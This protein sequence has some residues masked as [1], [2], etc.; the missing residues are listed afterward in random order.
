VVPQIVGSTQ[1]TCPDVQ[2]TWDS[3]AV[4]IGIDGFQNGYVE[5]TGTSSDCFYGQPS[6]Y[7]WYEMYPAGSVP[8]TNTVNPGDHMTAEVSYVSAT[9]LFT[10][11]ITDLTGHWTFTSAPTM[12]CVSPGVCA[13]ADSAEWIDESPYYEGFLGLTPVPQ[14]TMSG[15]SATINGVTHSISGWGSNVNWLAM[16]DYN[17]G[18]V[19]LGYGGE[20]LL[21]TK[22]VPLS[23]GMDGFFS[24]GN[25][26]SVTWISSGP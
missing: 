1:T 20:T 17:W 13:P 6:Y 25:T 18:P 26:F 9:G 10:T 14:I 11:T 23:D 7:A 3:N 16:V 5:Q 21:Y 2:K 8:I 4:W 24:R 12:N 15:A 22:A 19:A